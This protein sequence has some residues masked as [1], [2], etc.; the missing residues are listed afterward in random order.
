MR[1]LDEEFE[2]VKARVLKNPKLIELKK[3]RQEPP[4]MTI[5]ELSR[6]IF[7]QKRRR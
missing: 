2:K 5:D 1:K 3:K 7:G 6:E 4:S